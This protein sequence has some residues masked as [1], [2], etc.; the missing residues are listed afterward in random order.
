MSD[1]STAYD[2]VPYASKAFAQ[3]HPDRLATLATLFGLSPAPAGRCRVLEVGCGD[4]GNLLP[5]AFAL[6]GSTF[7][8]VDLAG[9][10]IAQAADEARALGLANVELHCADLMEWTPPAGPFDHVIAHGFFSWVPEVVRLRLLELCRERLAPHGVAFVSYN[11]LPGCHV[12][13]MLREMM[14]HHVRHVS[15]PALKISQA[16]ALLR[17]LVAGQAGEEYAALL[18]KEAQRLLDGKSDHALFHDDLGE[19][20]RPFYFHEFAALAARHGLQYLAEAD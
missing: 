12:R 2:A 9:R 16:K 13:A 8:G 19:I 1:A 4:G 6:P 10:A 15:E 18:R 3:T 20:N 11:A 17:L 7:V 14:L 5:L